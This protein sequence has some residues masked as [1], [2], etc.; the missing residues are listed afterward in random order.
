[1]TSKI[2][3]NLSEEKLAAIRALFAYNGWDWD[4][5]WEEP[6]EDVPDTPE[7]TNG[8][9][10]P[11]I[12]F[13]PV[14]HFPECP[15]C[16]CQPC[17]VHDMHRQLWWPQQAKPASSQNNKCRK[18]LYKKFWTMLSHRGVWQDGRYVD[19]KSRA[20]RIDVRRRRFLWQTVGMKR[21]IM[22]NCVIRQVREWF[23]NPDNL[24]Y[25]GHLWQ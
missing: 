9:D 19:R 13:P 17:I 1:M 10:D 23:P 2:S 24:P 14:P 4:S 15:E 5:N 11:E 16:F 6:R 3:A 20:I 7:P 8:Q 25:M 12:H 21:E 18:V 22:P